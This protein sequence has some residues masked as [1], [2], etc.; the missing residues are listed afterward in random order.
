MKRNQKRRLS[1][2]PS[3]MGGLP[4]RECPGGLVKMWI[5][6]KGVASVVLAA[7]ETGI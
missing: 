7:E 4:R 3:R 2:A 5:R 6:D 1:E